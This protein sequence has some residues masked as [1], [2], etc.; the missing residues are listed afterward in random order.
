MQTFSVSSL[1]S[2]A[3]GCGSA[4]VINTMVAV[5]CRDAAFILCTGQQP[6]NCGVAQGARAA[7]LS[8]ENLRQGHKRRAKSGDLN[9]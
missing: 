9:E 1:T 5:V 7:G 4:V 8:L 6:S 3:I 2:D